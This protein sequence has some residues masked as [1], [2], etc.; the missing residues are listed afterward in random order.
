MRTTSNALVVVGYLYLYHLIFLRQVYRR[1]PLILSG[2][3]T[4]KLMV[5]SCAGDVLYILDTWL[6]STLYVS[7][8]WSDVS[9]DLIGFG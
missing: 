7:P 5:A 4:R 9:L 8:E 3:K 6:T 1:H 2:N